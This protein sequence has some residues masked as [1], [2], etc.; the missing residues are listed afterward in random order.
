MSQILKAHLALFTVALIYGANYSIAK[1][2]LDDHYILPKGFILLRVLSAALVLWSLN[3]FL[4]KEKIE[5]QDYP[6]LILCAIFGVVINQVFFF[7]GLKL[8]TPI[9]A[10]LI[11]TTTPIL[12]LIA[13][14]ILIGERITVFK[15]LGIA[16]GAAG[17]ILLISYGKRIV[18]DSSQRLGDVLIFINAAS[19]GIYLVLVKSLMRKYQALTVIKW[20]FTIAIVF[21]IPLGAKELIAVDWASFPPPVWLSVF[22]VLLFATVAA[23]SLNAFALQT[24]NPS[25]VS[26]YIYLQPILAAAIALILLQDTLDWVKVASAVMIFAGVYLVSYQK[27]GG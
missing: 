20:A 25:T 2:V 17:A 7:S 8:T 18:F 23:Y 11:M 13:S 19:Y 10:S 27:K 16:L 4:P 3:R 1:I 14:T 21:L 26:I 22:Y 15:V 9:N 6:R 12:V 5:R 24:V